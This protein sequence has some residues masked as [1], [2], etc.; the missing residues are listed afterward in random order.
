MF[1]DFLATITFW[2]ACVASV[3]VCFRSK[4]GE[5]RVKDRAKNGSFN[6]SRDQ[7]RKSPSTV[8]FC[9]ET[10]RKRLLRRLHSEG[11]ISGLSLRGGGRGFPRLLRTWSL[12]TFKV[13]RR[14][15]EPKEPL[16]FD[17]L[18]TFVFTWPHK[19]LVI[20]LNWQKLNSIEAVEGKAA[21]FCKNSWNRE[22]RTVTRLIQKLNWETRK[23]KADA[24]LQ[25][26]QGFGGYP[27]AIIC[28]AT[29]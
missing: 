6:F 25:D 26:I 1:L 19:I 13:N 10:K 3:S 20:T 7:N 28:P 29:T 11:L 4:E 23:S 8:S 16:L 21:R 5:T 24:V 17:S 27:N 14:K 22:P 15:L 18:P 9:S 2:I 12:A